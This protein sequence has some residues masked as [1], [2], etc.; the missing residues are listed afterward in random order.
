M[1]GGGWNSSY[2]FRSESEPGI[3]VALSGAL[4]AAI[5]PAASNAATAF[6]EYIVRS[7]VESGCARRYAAKS[8]SAFS[9]WSRLASHTP[10]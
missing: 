9:V 2:L 7:I 4:A 10:R 6:V 3:S 1:L 8:A 5:R